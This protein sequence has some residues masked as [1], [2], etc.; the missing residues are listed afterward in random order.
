GK[1]V[2]FVSAG[3]N[4]VAGQVEQTPPAGTAVYSAVFLS[5]LSGAA[6]STRLVSRRFGTTATVAGAASDTPVVNQDGSVVAFR[7][8]AADPVAQQFPGSPAGN[9]FVYERA[10]DL[11]GL[12][13]HAPQQPTVGTGGTPFTPDSQGPLPLSISADGQS[14]AY[15]SQAAAL[16]GA[17]P[18]S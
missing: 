10:F 3:T 9:V 2:A 11:V 6:P 4:L 8:A 17:A 16:V 1:S 7:S 18:A 5:D 14:I 15:Q 12:V 13:S